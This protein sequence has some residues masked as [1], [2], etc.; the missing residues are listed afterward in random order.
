MSVAKAIMD[1][2]G[3]A[4]K[5]DQLAGVMGLSAGS[6][7]FVLKV[8]TA[9]TFGLV[10]Y[11]NGMYDLTDVG[12]AIVDRNEQRQRAAK[13]QAFLNVPL[14]RR[15][16]EEFKSRQLPPRPNG[17]EQAFIR[18]GVPPKSAQQAR[19]AFDKSATQAGYFTA[20]PDRL[21]EPIL[22]AAA[23]PPTGPQSQDYGSGGN[24][25]RAGGYA[26]PERPAPRGLHPFIE[27]L[28]DKLPPPETNWAPEGRAKWLM[29]ANNIFDMLYNGSGEVQ[30]VL[31]QNPEETK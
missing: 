20:G 19:L 5:T 22:G 15:T 16:F 8:T 1:H 9:R 11:A 14:Y 21:I 24:G 3:V 27:G 7:N 13:A 10:N 2:G 29:T 12:A 17:L 26:E 23:P 6:G 18:F 30:V 28:L 4:L 31:K 25:D